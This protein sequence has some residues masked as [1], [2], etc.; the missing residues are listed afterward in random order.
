MSF[1][2]VRSRTPSCY[3][4]SL[5]L[6]VAATAA[7]GGRGAATPPAPAPA[8]VGVL[9]LSPKPVTITSE[10]VGVLKSRRSSEIRPQVDGII[11]QIFVKSGERVAPGR[12]L[13]QIDPRR[14]QAA[15]ESNQASRAAQEAAVRFAEQQ[16][17]R[18]KQLL[19]AGAMSQQEYEQAETNLN[20]AKAALEALK[21]QEREA[22]VELQYYR[23]TSPTVGVVGDVPVRVGD[24]VTTSTV[25]TTVD[26]QAGLEAYI[27][28]PI[29]RAPDVRIGL[30]VRLMDSQ[31]A[32]LAD[33]AID[34]VSPQVDDRT[35]S[36]LVKAP[37][38]ASQSFRTEQFVRAVVVWRNEPGL[39]VPTTAVTRIN[40]QYFAFVAEPGDK[41]FVA[42]QHAVKLGELRG[43]E[44]VLV[45]GLKAGDR[46]IVSGVQK[47]RDGAPVQPEA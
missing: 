43:N 46:L 39:T 27:Q 41:G 8:P 16:F 40:G 14:E 31:G 28:V 15:L 19:D 23:V 6:L 42:R 20:T 37:V 17:V 3:S 21:A 12:A 4:C 13:L 26:Q 22:G 33:T 9:I 25:L 34:F 2:S 30:P 45:D 32:V 35:Q 18:A 24:R 44:Y 38:P 1:N 11:T 29:E 47:V 5:V 7:C 10:F 36:I